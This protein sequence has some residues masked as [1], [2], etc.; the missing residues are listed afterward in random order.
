MK[1][2][3]TTA[4][5]LQ[6]LAEEYRSCVNG[7]RL[8]LTATVSGINPLIDQF[9]NPEGIQKFTAYLDFRTTVHRYQQEH[10]ISGIVWRQ[11]I[12]R[13][14]VLNYPEVDEQLIAL[15]SDLKILQAAKP[16][17][18]QFWQQALARE[19]VNLNAPL[20]LYIGG[21][22]GQEY[23]PITQ[24]DVD[25][26]AGRSEW[27]TLSKHQQADFL[28]L[29]LQLGWG[30]LEEALYKRGWPESRSQFIVAVTPGHTPIS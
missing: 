4:G 13:D 1:Q 28:E 22:P 24:P 25:Q 16:T 30:K 26:I 2:L 15:A 17:V 3:Y 8:S 14:Q 12:H 9:L 20:D 6:I 19:A 21:N 10:Q 18:Y 11:L 5:L 7:Q 27:A 23:Q 29:V